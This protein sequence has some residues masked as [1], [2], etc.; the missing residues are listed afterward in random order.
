MK[1]EKVWIKQTPTSG[2][3]EYFLDDNEGNNISVHDSRDNALKAM[4]LER[5]KNIAFKNANYS[6]LIEVIKKEI[7]SVESSNIDKEEFFYIIK[8]HLKHF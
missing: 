8:N 1:I 4:E 7:K 6:S 2:K 3:F 5:V